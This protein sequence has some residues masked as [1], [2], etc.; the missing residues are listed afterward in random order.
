MSEDYSFLKPYYEQALRMQDAAERIYGMI[1]LPF[2]CMNVL[3]L[4]GVLNCLSQAG[5]AK[6]SGIIIPFPVP[7]GFNHPIHYCL[8]ASILHIITVVPYKTSIPIEIVGILWYS[9]K[10]R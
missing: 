2:Y 8:S 1:R 9:K 4:T 10:R 3:H 5:F 7:S 6:S